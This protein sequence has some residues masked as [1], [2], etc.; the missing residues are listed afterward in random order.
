MKS[1]KSLLIFLIVLLTIGFAS[2]TTTLTLVGVLNIGDNNDDFNIIFTSAA[3]DGAMRNDF[4]S[5][6]KQDLSFTSNVLRSIDDT[7]TLEYEVTNTSRNYDANVSVTCSAGENDYITFEYSPTA[8]TILAGK[9]EKGTLTAKMKKAVID[10]KDIKI[11]CEIV[12]TAEERNSLGDEYFA[13]FSKSGTLKSADWNTT[14]TY[15]AYKK[16]ITNIVFENKLIEHATDEN[17]IFDVSDAQDGSVMAYLVLNDDTLNNTSGLTDTT[18][19]YTLYIQG[20]TGVKAS[21]NAAGLFHDFTNLKTIDNLKYL[22]TASVTNMGS[23]FQNCSSLTTADFSNFDTSKVVNMDSMFYN[24]SSLTEL[25]LRSFKT[26]NVTTMNGM[27]GYCQNL[28]KLNIRNFDTSKV[29]SMRGLFQNTKLKELDL[30]N[31]NTSNVTTMNTMFERCASLTSLDLSNFNTSNVTDMEGMFFGCTSLTSLNI[32][33][34]N[35]E[36]VTTM[37]IMFYNCNKLTSLNVSSF[38]TSNVTTMTSMFEKCRSL[39]SLNLS[40]FDTSNVTDMQTIFLDCA[41]LTT[42]DISGFTADNIRD[43]QSLFTALPLTLKVYVK[44]ETVQTKVLSLDASNRPS[45]WTTANV[46][47][48]E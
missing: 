33:G 11:S 1:R 23:M 44:D 15:Y 48:K 35:T 22:S 45:A 26:S 12:A 24:C 4:I 46:I 27:F 28:E 39:T 43:D 19:A 20:D 21:I 13:P 30:S 37:N 3:L 40:N 42:L 32:S 34:F 18:S 8:M 16:N 6:D 38:N 41:S 14:E 25:D 9:T 47:I 7:T 10:D 31:F 2:V 36:K 29:T 17:L 5:N